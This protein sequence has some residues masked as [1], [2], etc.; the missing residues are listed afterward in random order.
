MTWLPVVFI[1]LGVVSY[2]EAVAKKPVK[3]PS[4][5]SGELQLVSLHPSGS[6]ES[7]ANAI[8]DSGIVVGAVDGVPGIWDA[9]A[10]VPVFAPLPGEGEGVACSINKNGEIAGWEQWPPSPR[11]WPS[12]SAPPVALPLPPD[13][14]RGWAS[15]VGQDGVVVG[16]VWI[17]NDDDTRT[18]WAVAW[19][20]TDSGVFGP[21]F[22]SVGGASDVACIAPGLHVAVGRSAD[23]D[24]GHVATAWD[25]VAVDD[26]SLTVLGSTVLVPDFT[27]EAFAATERG[28]VTG[29]VKG[30]DMAFV[31]RNG[32]VTLLPSGPRNEYGVGY[33]LNDSEVVGKTGRTWLSDNMTAT[34]WNSRNKRQDLVG[35]YFGDGWPNTS[36]EG[37]NAAGEMVGLGTGG[38]WL[39]RQQ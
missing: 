5:D 7:W 24:Y 38:A 32:S 39:L 34:Q 19:R 2:S 27:G 13:A 11:Y 21:A 4:D 10:E 16:E 33:D 30:L 29:I 9:R 8:S 35:E 15:G 18:T 17:T 23:V 20:I 1:A 37:I 22:L 25:L 12:P 6:V 31:I 26:G 36:V 28:D 14:E 3:P